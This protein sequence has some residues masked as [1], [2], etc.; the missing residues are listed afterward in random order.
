MIA[1]DAL[2]SAEIQPVGDALIGGVLSY[3]NP[4]TAESEIPVARP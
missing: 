3:N 1:V 4:E 2:L